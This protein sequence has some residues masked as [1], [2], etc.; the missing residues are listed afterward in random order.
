MF[1]KRYSPSSALP[2]RWLLLLT[3]LLAL[4][5][6]LPISQRAQRQFQHPQRQLRE[7]PVKRTKKVSPTAVPGQILVRFRP[8]SKGK[9][10]G[11]Q[12]VLEKTGRQIP[13]V[14]KAVS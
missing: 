4:V 7:A 9:Q 11:R 13:L 3:I 6:L 5:A 12:V 8:E 2:Y 14:I 1:L 10:L